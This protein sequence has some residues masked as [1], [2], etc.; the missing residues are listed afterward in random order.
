MDVS[1]VAGIAS[2]A[3]NANNSQTNDAVDISVLNMA[4]DAQVQGAAALIES[5]AES[6]QATALPDNVGGNINVTA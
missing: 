1:S 2:L 3:T 6:P 4:L 5:I